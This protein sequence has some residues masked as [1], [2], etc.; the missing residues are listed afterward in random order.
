MTTNNQGM[1]RAMAFFAAEIDR[2][3]AER[4]FKPWRNPTPD[5]D[6]DTTLY[7]SPTVEPSILGEFYDF[8]R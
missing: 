4:P 3:D 7:A 1:G 8:D 6:G 2:D 5:A